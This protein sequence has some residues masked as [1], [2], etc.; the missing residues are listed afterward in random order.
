MSHLSFVNSYQLE[1]TQI[2]RVLV[3]LNNKN[4]CFEKS[5]FSFIPF[6]NFAHD[7]CITC[8]IHVFEVNI[9]AN[10]KVK[11]GNTNLHTL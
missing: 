1:S 5:D 8:I 4:T 9:F 11:N 10:R 2:L 6:F 7:I 3:S